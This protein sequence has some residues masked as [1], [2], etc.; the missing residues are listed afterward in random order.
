MKILLIN[1]ALLVALTGFG[2]C[3]DSDVLLTSQSEVDEFVELYPSCSTLS[4]NLRI[5]SQD[6]EDP[7]TDLTGLNQLTTITGSLEIVRISYTDEDIDS[8]I[9]A[10]LTGLEG[11]TSVGKLIIGDEF[12]YPFTHIT[13]LAPLG[14]LTGEIETIELLQTIFYDDLPDFESVTSLGDFRM[15]ICNGVSETPTFPNLTSLRSFQVQ[16]IY[17]EEDSLTLVTIPNVPLMESEENEFNGVIVEHCNNLEAIVGGE[18][19]QA[20]DEVDIRSNEDLTTITAFDDLLWTREFMYLYACHPEAFDSF[21]NLTLSK[22]MWIGV[23]QNC[24]GIWDADNVNIRVGEFAPHLRVRGYGFN[25]WVTGVEEVNLAANTD[26]LT[27][28]FMTLDGV[29]ELNA[30][31]MLDSLIQGPMDVGSMY[32][33][34]KN[35][36]AFPSFPNLKYLAG[37]LT[38]QDAGFGNT[39]SDLSGFESIQRVRKNITVRG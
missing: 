39:I 37:T 36:S 9:P 12:L 19:L 32:V 29:E 2:Q 8:I 10:S 38:I 28:L 33:S 15:L 23:N 1:L 16:G 25:L 34:A 20:C 5:E 31:S 11:L 18:G 14:N 6:T 30:F 3:P 21:K 26:K 22:E 35:M 24:Q 27:A 17:F 7:I 13:S 4:G